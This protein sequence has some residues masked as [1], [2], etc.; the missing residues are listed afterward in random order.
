[1][2]SLCCLRLQVEDRTRDGSRVHLGV[3]RLIQ[4]GNS[5]VARAEVGNGV[6]MEQIQSVL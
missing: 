4:V 1:V 6:Q 3:V 2:K 5:S